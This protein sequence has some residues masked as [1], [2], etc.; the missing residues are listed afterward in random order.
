[1]NGFLYYI[2][3]SEA[4]Q[5]GCG[6][7]PPNE[8]TGGPTIGID[9]SR[10]LVTKVRAAQCHASQ[11]P[12]YSGSPDEEAKRL[13]CHEYFVLAHPLVDEAKG[14]DLFEPLV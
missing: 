4:T 11:N 8:I 10:H 6:V 3:P 5:Q 14:S 12:P 9:V 2:A 1:M 7:A 13:A